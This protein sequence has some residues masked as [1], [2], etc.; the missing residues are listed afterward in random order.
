MN[1]QNYLNKTTNKF[2]AK[3]KTKNV[4]SWSSECGTI[5]PFDLQILN[6]NYKYGI[7]TFI[8]IEKFSISGNLKKK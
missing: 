1:I 2:N 3:Q 7:K 5:E 4:Q 6:F 8:L